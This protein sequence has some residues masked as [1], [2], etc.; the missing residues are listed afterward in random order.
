MRP[1]TLQFFL[2]SFALISWGCGSNSLPASAGSSIEMKRVQSAFE[3]LQKESDRGTSKQEFTKQ[4]DDTLARIGDLE[5]SEKAS[6]LGLPND[7]VAVVYDYFRQASIAYAISTQFVGAGWDAASNKATDSTSDGER[8]SLG[9]AF[10]ELDP[11][12]MMSRRS[13]L[14]DLLQIA[15]A[16][17]RDA[18]VMIETL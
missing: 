16:E 9:A 1:L 6:D 8:E 11:V 3:D 5:T 7:K 18:G 17:T 13:T 12:H 10:P 2:L 4:V 15:H 14:Y